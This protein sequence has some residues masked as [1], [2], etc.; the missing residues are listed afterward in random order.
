MP[1]IFRSLKNTCTIYVHILR[2]HLVYWTASPRAWESECLFSHSPLDIVYMAYLFLFLCLRPHWS[3]TKAEVLY[4]CLLLMI[5]HSLLFK[6]ICTCDSSTIYNW[7]GDRGGFH[8]VCH[9]FM[10][11][12]ACEYGL[13]KRYC[14]WSMVYHKVTRTTVVKD[15]HLCIFWWPLWHCI[16]SMVG[17]V[18]PIY[19]DGAC[20]CLSVTALAASTSA[21]TRDLRLYLDINMWIIEKTITVH[22]YTTARHIRQTI[23]YKF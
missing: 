9:S 20:V 14:L 12:W 17:T 10:V 11:A 18:E 13:C 7:T 6:V 19:R 16:Y 21:Y 15:P 23:N 1:L 5:S 3:S 22:R 4:F 2:V 8:E